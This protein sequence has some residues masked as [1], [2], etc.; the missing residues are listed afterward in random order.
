MLLLHLL[1]PIRVLNGKSPAQVLQPGEPS[2]TV[3]LVVFG[4]NG[5]VYTVRFHGAKLEPKLSGVYSYD[6][7]N[8]GMQV[9]F[10]WKKWQTIHFLG[11]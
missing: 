7:S 11:S 2:F 6:D 4:F 5:F 10:T 3:P 9:L 8:Q 1:M